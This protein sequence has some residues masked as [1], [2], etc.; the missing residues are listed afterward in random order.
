MGPLGIAI[1]LGITAYGFFQRAKSAESTPLERWA[2]RCVF[3]YADETPKVHWN[4]PEH[5]PIA[6]A[7][8]NAAT[9]GVEANVRFRLRLIA[10]QSHHRGGSTGGAGTLAQEARLEYRLVLPCFHPEHS[11]YQ[12]T[13]RLLREGDN[14]ANGEAGEVAASGNLI[15]PLAPSTAIDDA[16][17]ARKMDYQV[18]HGTPKINTRSATLPNKSA[19]QVVDI[20]GALVLKPQKP[21]QRI[22]G[23]ILSLTYWPDRS[24]SEGYAALTLTTYSNL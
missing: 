14:P 24:V 1:L 7:E 17:P 13:L 4:K 19:L 8:L 22:E 10:G 12:W 21:L 18:E 9:F 20:S 16:E 2:R 5:A 11:D 3:G 15:A 6:I 23:A